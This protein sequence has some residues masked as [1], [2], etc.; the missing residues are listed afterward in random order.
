[1]SVEV[2]DLA[3]GV[4]VR[5]YETH[6]PPSGADPWLTVV[7]AHGGSFFRGALDWPEAD[8]VAHRLA[9]AG[10]RVFSVDYSLASET[11]TAPV[12]AL[13]IARVLSW[14]VGESAG[15]V[16]VGG[17]SAGGHL[18]TLAALVQAEARRGGAAVRAADALVLAYPTMHRAL[19]EDAE[20]TAATAA[21]PEARRYGAE[22]V[23]EMYEV[24]L[25]PAARGMSEGSRADGV[26][27]VAGE[28]PAERL[29]LLPPTVIATADVDDLR[30]SGE[31]FAEQLRDAGVPVVEYTQPGTVHG[32]LNRPNESD[33]A[34]A[35][36]GACVDRIVTEL[37]RLLPD[38]SAT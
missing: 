17:A 29:A 4:P 10:A 19:P 13:D 27:L 37:H 12:P 5:R 14:V 35:D 28:L 21:L 8:W 11:V 23:A 22:R 36:A 32:F 16:A 20:L 38:S 31:R 1:M 2:V 18:A 6:A 15:P 34:R 33:A 7:W 30:T 26:P 3:V 9:D 24:Y 25:G